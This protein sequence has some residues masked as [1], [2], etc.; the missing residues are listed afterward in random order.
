MTKSLN[1]TL[2]T[3]LEA[4]FKHDI[5]AT[6]KLL[7]LLQRERKALEERNYDE[8]QKIIG[9][10]QQLLTILEFHANTRQQLLTAAGYTDEPSTLVAADQQAPLVA[11][12]W[13]KLADEW[14]QCQELNEINER[15]AKRT[16][17]V[18][19]QILDLLRGSNSKN[20]LY[21]SKGDATAPSGGR[22]ITSA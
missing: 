21:T 16:R 18:V 4:T 15:I 8:F 17:L 9:Q 1:N 11:K 13:R 10:K 5:P 14:R 2:W 3:E 7:D 6:S 12:A 22:A 19:G 20:K